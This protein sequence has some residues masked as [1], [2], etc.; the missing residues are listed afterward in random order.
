MIVKVP[1]SMWVPHF[2]STLVKISCPVMKDS[3]VPSSETDHGFIWVSIPR[4][5][6]RAKA[7]CQ[8]LLLHHCICSYRENT[9]FPIIV[10]D[11]GC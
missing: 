2:P 1:S 4:F 6:F 7:L 3:Y 5:L 10:G 11:G 9:G 8:L